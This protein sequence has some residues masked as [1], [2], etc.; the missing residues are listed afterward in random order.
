VSCCACTRPGLNQ[1]TGA[2]G[3]V[4]AGAPK[5][6]VRSDGDRGGGVAMADRKRG[7]RGART[8]AAGWGSGGAG[9]R[10]T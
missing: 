9:I 3:K 6:V 1:A 5:R 10:P 2:A 4:P 7:Y 8:P